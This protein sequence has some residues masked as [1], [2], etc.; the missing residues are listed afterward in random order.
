MGFQPMIFGAE[1]ALKTH[2]QDARVTKWRCSANL[3]RIGGRTG[4]LFVMLSITL[5]GRVGGKVAGNFFS[6]E[7]LLKT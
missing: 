1:T 5:L 4:A 2:G 7:F 3:W 6:P